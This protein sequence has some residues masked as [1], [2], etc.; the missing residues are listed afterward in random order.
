M[1]ATFTVKRKLPLQW[2]SE[3]YLQ[4]IPI[5]SPNREKCAFVI[6]YPSISLTRVEKNILE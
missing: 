6:V 1:C 2:R 4:A 5:S 3:P